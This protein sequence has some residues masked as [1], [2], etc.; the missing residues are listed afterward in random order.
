MRFR[1]RHLAGNSCSSSE[2]SVLLQGAFDLALV[3]PSWDHRCRVITLG[4]DLWFGDAIVLRFST[5]DSAGHQARHEEEILGFLSVHAKRVHIIDGDSVDVEVVWK[6]LW[7]RVRAIANANRQSLK[8]FIDLSTCPR[9][10]GIGLLAGMF[11]CGFAAEV[12]VFY[13]E[14]EYSLGEASPP[15]TDYPFSIGQWNTAPIPFLSGAVNPARKKAFIVSV[16]FEGVKTARVLS[17]EDPDRVALIYPVPGVLPQYEK[18]VQ[19][20]NA[21][22]AEEFGVREESILRVHAADAVGVWKALSSRALDFLGEETYYLC[23]GTK[24]H[25]LGMALRALCLKFPTVLYNV[26]EKHTFVEVNPTGVFW[27]FDLRDISAMPSK[28]PGVF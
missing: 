26:P 14:G 5:R 3:C 8:G 4:A 28:V 23:C 2:A 1:Q 7:S 10:Y 20:C 17:K 19:E 9:Y 11:E 22:V 24:P 18:L 15:A 6:L 13:S 12:S 27:R 25:A 16:G 21:A